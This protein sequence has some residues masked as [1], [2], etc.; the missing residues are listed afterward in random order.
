[1]SSVVLRPDGRR[2][3][4]TTSNTMTDF[5]QP[6]TGLVTR[7]WEVVEKHSRWIIDV[8]TCLEC[9]AQ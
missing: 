7:C 6:P 4:V 5:T 3:V 9:L 2:C 8:A 1:M